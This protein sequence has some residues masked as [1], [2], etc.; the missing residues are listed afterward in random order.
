MIFIRYKRSIIL[1][2]LIIF[3]VYRFY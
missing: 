2:K 1:I 3:R